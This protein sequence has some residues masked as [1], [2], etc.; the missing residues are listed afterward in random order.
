MAP[1]LQLLQWIALQGSSVCCE[2]EFSSL[3]LP[4]GGITKKSATCMLLIQTVLGSHLKH[5]YNTAANNVEQLPRDL[6]VC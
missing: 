1:Q 6:R 2:D 3:R 4:D 5:R